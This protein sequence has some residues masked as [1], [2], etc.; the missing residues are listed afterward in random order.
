MVLAGLAAMVPVS[1]CPSHE[2]FIVN[3]QIGSAS[4]RRKEQERMRRSNETQARDER[5]EPAERQEST[6][7]TTLDSIEFGPMQV[8]DGGISANFVPVLNFL[9]SSCWSS[10]ATTNTCISIASFRAPDG[11][12]CKAKWRRHSHSTSSHFN[13]RYGLDQGAPC[14]ANRTL[15]T[16]CAAGGFVGSPRRACLSA[17][18]DSAGENARAACRNGK[19][20]CSGAVARV[21]GA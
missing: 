1:A 10:T 14:C 6:A 5:G 12:A 4:E 17:S 11:F 9:H 16:T 18:L 19:K 8:S 7:S 3:Q 13:T 21:L 15:V 2:V 20:P